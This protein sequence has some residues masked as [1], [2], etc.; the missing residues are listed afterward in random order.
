MKHVIAF[1][2]FLAVAACSEPKLTEGRVVAKEYEP[3]R[4]WVAMVPFVISTG[5]SFR[6]MYFPMTYRD[7]EDFIV[8]IEGTSAEG[9]VVRERLYV[10]DEVHWNAI[11]LGEWVSVKNARL[12]SD[13]PVQRK[14]K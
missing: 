7:D 11:Q 12:S 13:D 8:V 4:T 3:E 5:N 6:T 2:A 10:E 9:N 1:L 14:R